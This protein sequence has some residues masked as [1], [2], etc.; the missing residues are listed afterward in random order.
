MENAW[1]SSSICHHLITAATCLSVQTLPEQSDPEFFEMV[2]YFFHRGCQLVEP[3]LVDTMRSRAPR[4]DKAKKVRGILQMMEPCHH[5]IEICFPLKKDDGSFEMI[6]GYRSQH[7][8]H[9]VPTKGGE[10]ARGG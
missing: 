5:V 2:E 6:T 7:S 10:S 4:D 3:H 8:Q 9:R 1:H